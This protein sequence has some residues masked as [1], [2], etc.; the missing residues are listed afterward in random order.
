[1]SGPSLPGAKLSAP[2]EQATPA[3]QS[4][5]AEAID[6]LDAP[7]TVGPP[8]F[9]LDPGAVGAGGATGW[10]C[11]PTGCCPS[12]P[13]GACPPTVSPPIAASLTEA[14]SVDRAAM[15][16]AMLF[17]SCADEAAEFVTAWHTPP[18]TRA[19]E[20]SLREPR[21]S[22]DAAGSVAVA[23]L[24]T[25]PEHTVW[26]GHT[27]A[28]PAAEAADGPTPIRA[29]FHGP[30]P[31]CPAFRALAAPGPVEACDTDRTSH[32]ASPLHD[33]VPVD[34]PDAPPAT[35][36]S[37][38]ALR[39]CT[40]PTHPAGQSNTAL[41]DE[42]DDGP[43][44]GCPA[45][46]RPVAGSTATK[47]AALDAA[48][49][50]SPLHPP[51]ATV[52]SVPAPEPRACGD[53]PVSRA[54]VDDDAE[55]PHPPGPPEH[56]TTADACDTLTGPETGATP[57]TTSPRT[58]PAACVADR[59]TTSVFASAPHEPP[60][61]WAAHC[62]DPRLSRT[63]TMS[64]EAPP[65]V[66]P[67]P[68]PEHGATGQ[69][70][71]TLA[72][73]DAVNT[74]PTSECVGAPGT[75][76]A[77]AAL[78]GPA[79]VSPTRELDSAP[80]RPAVDSHSLAPDVDRTGTCALDPA[81]PVIFP[82]VEVEPRPEQSHPL[83][84]QSTRSAAVE[85]F[86]P[87]RP[88]SFSHAPPRTSHDDFAASLLRVVSL[89]EMAGTDPAAASPSDISRPSVS[90]PML[91]VASPEQPTAP[92]P[93]D[94][95]PSARTAPPAPSR[96]PSESRESSSEPSRSAPSRRT[97]DEPLHRPDATRQPDDSTATARLPTR[98]GESAR[99]GEPRTSPL[100]RL[101]QRSPEASQLLF[102]PP[103]SATATTP[104]RVARHL[105][106][107]LLPPCLAS[108]LQP[109]A[110]HPA[111]TTE[112][113]EPDLAPQPDTPDKPTQLSRCSSPV[114]ASATT[115]E[116]D[117]NAPLEPQPP[118][119]PPPSTSADGAGSCPARS[120]N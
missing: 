2:P 54:L 100:L 23:A 64:P 51:P 7:G 11:P 63:P 68:R 99:A 45:I 67:D 85:P 119:A 69:S 1:V 113:P 107:A 103:P 114:S 80:Q 96:A 20:P 95:R 61:P 56:C 16:G 116:H 88:A 94:T 43:R 13:A 27:R 29:R 40:V 104:H 108:V 65:L 42:I 36:P 89:V 81:A 17:A 83:P 35:A 47:S 106:D 30:T 53:T 115:V 78:S 62:V 98:V 8:E 86:P 90:P 14:F 75:P 49:L 37:Q 112:A 110:V 50:V 55:P 82:D 71:R 24:D 111:V 44:T 109:F 120:R 9:A 38:A 77:S 101:S 74:R 18:N 19:H 84:P 41:D 12:G 118:A 91:P 22:G 66:A 25:F 10:S 76:P 97:V 28:A 70:T 60:A 117:R 58:A 92:A 105:A 48:E 21:G 59:S 3:A 39:V 5:V 102:A 93:H 33:A 32:P 52:Q 6:Q 26:P 46:G 87:S 57:D 79:V 15:S 4:N 31:D 72:W 34:V 73:L